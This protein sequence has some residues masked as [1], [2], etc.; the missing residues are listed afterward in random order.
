MVDQFSHG[1][2]SIFSA[3]PFFFGRLQSRAVDIDAVIFG[4][5]QLCRLMPKK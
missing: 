2:Q 1:A 4:K 5:S 3:E